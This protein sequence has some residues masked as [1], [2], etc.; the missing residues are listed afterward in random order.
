VAMIFEVRA[1]TGNARGSIARAGQ[2]L[3]INP[4]TLRNWVERAEADCGAV[5]ARQHERRQERRSPDWRARPGNCGGQN[6]ILK[7]ASAYT[8]REPDPRHPR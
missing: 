6:E 3:G 1:E 7:A 4:E 5:A 8:A 2:R